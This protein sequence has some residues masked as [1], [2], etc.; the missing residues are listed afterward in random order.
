MINLNLL[1]PQQKKEIELA[2]FNRLI[3][4]LGAWLLSILVI[5]SLLLASAYFCLYIFLKA[6]NSLIEEK[7]HDKENQHLTEIEKS[8]QQA[9][10]QIEK[11]SAKGKDLIIWTPLLE[12][13]S[14]IVP[15]GIYLKNFSSQTGT[16]RITISGWANTR[17]TLLAFEKALKES[18]C[19]ADI[20]SPLANLIKQEDISFSF[21]FLPVK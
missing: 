8:I 6:Q 17:D 19:F 4:S 13:L 10:Q 14:K 21:S 7:Q 18:P 9:N 5:F 2:N 15:S 20:Q 12:E 3:V 16:Y 11:V 1:P